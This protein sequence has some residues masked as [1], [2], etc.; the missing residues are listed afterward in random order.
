MKTKQLLATRWLAL[1]CGI[2]AL[3][4][5][6][7]AKKPVKPPPEPPP[8]A[9]PA[10]WVFSLEGDVRPQA[11]SDV[12]T[13]VGGAWFTRA[14]GE[15]LAPF[16]LAPRTDNGELQ[17]LTTDLQWLLGDT[18]TVE[19]GW[20]SAVNQAGEAAGCGVGLTGMLWLADGTPV[21]LGVCPADVA[22]WANDIND[23]GLVV[24][25]FP[26]FFGATGAGSGVVVPLDNTGDGEPDTWFTDLDAD[27][28]NDLFFPI[29]PEHYLIP[30][31]IN[32]DGQVALTQI[33][34]GPDVAYLLTP[35]YDDADGDGNPWFADVDGDGFN[36]LLIALAPP[37]PGEAAAVYDLNNL[38]QVVG[39]SNGHV[40]LWEIVD[41]EQVVTEFGLLSRK[42]KSMS[43]AGINDAGH[44][45]GSSRKSRSAGP[46]WLYQDGTFHE[47]LSLVENPEGVSVLSPSG[48]N[49]HGWICGNGFVAVRV[50]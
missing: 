35:D 42:V 50:E 16:S 11:I 18:G 1:A 13:V 41:G 4:A 39:R 32:E 21:N 47:L 29:A 14:D 6:A 44:I 23:A 43:P 48:I 2:L 5:S 38:G 12:G 49:N 40:V 9:G 33:S 30:R 34:S 25:E 15:G 17:Y 36:D 3:A 45:V 46:S 10:Y 20:C 28:I 19:S 7:D 31:A 26:R 22:C 8:P 27:G 24:V 37:E